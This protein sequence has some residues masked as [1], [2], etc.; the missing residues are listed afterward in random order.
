M[1][2][3]YIMVYVNVIQNGHLEHE[4]DCITSAIVALAT[5]LKIKTFANDP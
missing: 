5:C 3:D 2:I 4:S 1:Q